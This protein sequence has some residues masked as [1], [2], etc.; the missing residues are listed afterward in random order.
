MRATAIATLF[1]TLS[2]GV[3]AQPEF[4]KKF[5]R[6]FI[7]TPDDA[8][9]HLPAGTF[10]L[11]GSLWLDGKK[12]VV[13]RGAGESQTI[14]DFAGQLSGAEGLKITNSSNITV[15]DLTVQ[16]TKGDGIKAQ[17]VN[18]L[19][20]RKVRAEWTKGP[21]KD[22]GGYGLYPVQCT[23]VLIDGCT[24]RGASDAGIYVGQ[25]KFIV[26]M[27]LKMKFTTTREVYWSLTFRI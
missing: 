27:S 8:V 21:D 20:L 2:Y 15:E 7:E 6:L 16:N 4:Q 18:G 5:Q 13:I 19:T 25:S 17:L 14:L 12:N 24:A 10:R 22:N 11:E 23:Q 9:I 3:S 26:P 1:L